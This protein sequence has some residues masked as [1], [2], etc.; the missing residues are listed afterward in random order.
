MLSSLIAHSPLLD[1][2]CI[3][4]RVIAAGIRG[5]ILFSDDSGHSWTQAQVPVST[6]LVALAFPNSTQGWAV[7]HGGIVLYS[8]DGG[9]SWH[10]QLDGIAASKLAIEYYQSNLT[11][12]PD[13]QLFLE[14][15]RS[16]AVEGETQSFMD[17]FFVDE[18]CGYVVGT[19]NRI[20]MT[21]DGG[22][23]WKPLM[24]LTENPGELHFYSVAGLEDQLYLAGEQGK[25]WRHDLA[26]SRFVVADT[27]YAGTLFGVLPGAANL[28]F[29]YGMRGSLFRSTDRGSTWEK[30]QSPI[31]GGITTT[32]VLAEGRVLIADQSGG[33][34]LSM[35][36]GRH[37]KALNVAKPMAYAGA[38]VLSDNA[39]VM[40]GALGVRIETV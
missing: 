7:G 1:V 32:L 2:V 28:L 6:D 19:F 27:Y 11:S 13:A 40:V 24:H 10:K 36:G 14:R 34:A 8:E 21:V 16:L 35:D 39:V 29:A 18:R 12:L 33:V 20:F 38:S 31:Q 15:E 23:N 26:S 5:S 37:F 22:Q 30:I 3:D 9:Q 17:V 4:K 25:V